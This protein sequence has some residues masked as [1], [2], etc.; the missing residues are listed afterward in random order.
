[1]NFD[2]S[3][4]GQPI[5][6]ILALDGGGQ[7]LIPLIARQCSSERAQKEL[8]GRSAADLFPHSNAPAGALAG[9]WL[10]F[11]CFDEAH[12]L[13]QDDPSPE[14]SYWHAILHR[15][16]PDPANSA[17]WFR[18]LG[19]HPVFPALAALARQILSRY[20]DVRLADARLELANHWNPFEFIHFCE[21]AAARPGSAAEQAALEIQRAEWQLLFDY[22]ARPRT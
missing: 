16:Q 13:A 8:S 17:Y 4:Y 7:R 21:R 11:S 1:M 22:C 12:R 9:L 5:H 14:G 15:Q 19:T 2:P 10:Y 18:R 6:R 20:P 3:R